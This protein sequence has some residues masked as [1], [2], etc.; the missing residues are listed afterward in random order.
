MAKPKPLS[1][2]IILA[3]VLSLGIL[4]QSEVLAQ[5]L[6]YWAQTYGCSGT[7][8]AC[9][10]Q[11]TSDGGFIVAGSTDSFGAG[12]A[13]FW[14]LKLD[15]SGNALWQK[16]YGGTDYDYASSIQQTPDGGYIVAGETESFGAGRADLWVLKLDES[17]NA[18]WQKTY[19]GTDYDNAYSIQQTLDGGYIM[20]GYTGSFGAGSADFWVLKLDSSGLIS[21]ECPLGVDSDATVT[22]TTIIGAD[23]SAPGVSSTAEI[24]APS[25][26]EDTDCE[27]QEQCRSAPGLQSLYLSTST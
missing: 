26:I 8:Y 4:P 12:K 3:F 18:L 10:I 6:E 11:Q 17:G 14:V 5:P 13:D 24:K 7:D 25:I 22:D 27:I 21:D 1:I 23:T 2:L 16:T 20:A 19:G 15:E 9:S